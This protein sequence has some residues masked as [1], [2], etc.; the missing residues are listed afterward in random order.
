MLY[1]ILS[2]AKVH[3]GRKEK[4]REKWNIRSEGE[5]KI[6]RKEKIFFKI[7]QIASTQFL[8]TNP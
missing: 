6:K 7:A 8:L 4:E 3:K 2:D 1:L 5:K